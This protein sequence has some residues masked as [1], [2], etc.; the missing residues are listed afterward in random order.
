[1][2]YI[3]KNNAYATLAG[4]LTDIATSVVLATGKGALFAVTAPEWTYVT[5]EDSSGNIETVKVTARSTDTLTIVRAQDGTAA[6]AWSIGDICE[7]RPCAAALNDFSVAPQIVGSSAKTTI[8]DADKFG[9]ADSA[10]SDVLK[11]FTWQNLKATLINSA[12]TWTAIQI[13]TNSMIKL[14]GSSTGK[15]TLTSANSSA[16][17]YT[18]TLPAITDTVVTKTTTDTLTNKRITARSSTEASSAT[19]TINTDNVDFHSITAL[20]AAITSMTSNLTGTPVAGDV[21]IIE[22][23]DNGTARAITW[24]ASFEASTVD[25]PTTTVIST[26]LTVGFIW[27][28]TTSKWRCV[29]AV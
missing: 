27:N 15:T 10:A 11:Y 6:R 7:C 21:L 26:K 17:D 9:I 3:A 8:V 14:L 18:L 12:M 29:G 1:M 5:F 28:A 4:T 19:P 20:A 25:L 22:I 23:T 16:T 13:F 24:G 2:S